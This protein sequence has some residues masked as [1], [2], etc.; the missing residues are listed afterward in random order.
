M[1]KAKAPR[2]TDPDLDGLTSA[3]RPAAQAGLGGVDSV[4]QDVEPVREPPY[5]GLPPG[6][7]PDLELPHSSGLF[8]PMMRRGNKPRLSR[9]MPVKKDDFKP[10]I[11]SLSP[12]VGTYAA[13]TH[14]ELVEKVQHLLVFTRL[15]TE[16]GLTVETKPTA[17]Q[18]VAMSLSE[19]QELYAKLN[20]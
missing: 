8:G 13:I 20:I 19:L 4:D 3:D 12:T 16:A 15:L 6:Y 14:N 11:S 5:T 7:R 9:S 18:L 1:A 17:E 10:D 2:K